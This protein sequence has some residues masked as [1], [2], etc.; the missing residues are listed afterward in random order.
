MHQQVFLSPI[1]R[2]K[3]KVTGIFP[4]NGLLLLDVE[5]ENIEKESSNQLN[6][7]IDPDQLLYVIYTS[8]TTGNPKRRFILTHTNVVRL[9]FNDNDLFDFSAEDVWSMFHSFT[10]DFSVWEMYGALLFGGKLVMVPSSFTKDPE[11]FSSLLDAEGVT[12]LNQTPSSYNAI[13]SYLLSKDRDLKSS[14]FNFRRRKITTNY[15]EK[16]G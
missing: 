15:S 6:T 5:K 16:L 10:F 3:A 8:G 1:R 4:E 13:Q 2:W 7:S 9:F 14:L 11:L 12:V